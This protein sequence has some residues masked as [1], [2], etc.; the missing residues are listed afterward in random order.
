MSSAAPLPL[1]AE[2]LAR[3]FHD[4]PRQIDVLRDASLSVRPGEFVAVLGRSGAG[5]TTLLNLLGL[6]DHPDAGRVVVD[7]RDVTR[8]GG[9]ARA[10][11]RGRFFGFVFQ[12]YHLLLEFTA[13]ENVLL[14]PRAAG[15]RADR[16]KAE[17]LLERVGLGHR[18]TAR[19][20][21]LSGGEKQR[22]AIARALAAEPRVLLADEPTGNLDE[23][24]G[25][26]VI[27]TLFD[28]GR[29]LGQTA[30]VVT[31]D[32]AIAGRADRVLHLDAGV[33]HEG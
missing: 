1:A 18:L 28:L 33:L 17:T 27:E 23:A 21:T 8:L 3:V 13:L 26:Q 20:A 16:A 6:L 11:L 5:K 32:A 22:T 12:S 4:G 7:G 30:V 2:S 25:A 29:A 14:A 31:H 19:P 10:R 9:G 15:L 24:T